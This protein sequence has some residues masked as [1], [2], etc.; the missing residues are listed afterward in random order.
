MIFRAFANVGT[1]FAL[2]PISLKNFCEYAGSAADTIIKT[3][4]RI[5]Y[6]GTASLKA[7]FDLNTNCFCTKKFTVCAS[8]VAVRKLK[9]PANPKFYSILSA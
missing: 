3:M 9:K 5:I 4:A 8:A 6:F 7:A 2:T 1:K